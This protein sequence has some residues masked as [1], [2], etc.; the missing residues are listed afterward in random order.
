MVYDDLYNIRKENWAFSAST[1]IGGLEKK[2]LD[3][4]GVKIA[5]ISSGVDMSNPVINPVYNGS[6]HQEG[7]LN[8]VGRYDP[9]SGTSSIGDDP[10][11]GCHGWRVTSA[12]WQF[13][14]NADYYVAD[15]EA[16]GFWDREV[17]S[18][19]QGIICQGEMVAGLEYALKQNPDIIVTSKGYKMSCQNV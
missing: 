3:G 13:A 11:N 17:E 7:K 19:V 4:T 9:D 15:I 5:V 18:R 6:S 14:P 8:T 10:S 16:D 2:E 1:G 12:V